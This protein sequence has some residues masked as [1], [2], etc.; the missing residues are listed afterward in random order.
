MTEC[1]DEGTLRA[2]LADP[3]SL[4]PED[5]KQIESHLTGCPTCRR[6]LENL[7]VLQTRVDAHMATL[8]PA[9]APDV[10][11]ALQK[12]RRTL[13]EQRTIPSITPA[14]GLPLPLEKQGSGARGRNF[15]QTLSFVRPSRR[16]ALV[17]GL[18]AAMLVLS[19]AAF[20][21]MRAAADEFLQSFRAK[22][23][24]FVPVDQSRIQQIMQATG[25]P[26]TL[27]LTAPEV[28]GNPR[29]IKVNSLDEATKLVNFAPGQPDAFPSAPT[30]TDYTVHEQAR[31]QTQVNI[32][33]TRELLK[34]LNISDVTLPDQLGT[35]PITADVPAT[36]QTTYSGA[37]YHFTLLQGTT[38]TVNL[39][40][41]VE[42]AQLGKAGLR[43]LGMQPDQ[44][45][46]LSREIDWSST[47]VVPFPTGLDSVVHVQVG[48]ADGLMVNAPNEYTG[49]YSG[50]NATV[51]YWQKGDR[52][53]VL[54]G[55]GMKVTPD[56]VLVVAKSVK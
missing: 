12:M 7:R 13:N 46:K 54:E 17:S 16:P 31:L 51:I 25:D 50:G 3:A 10:Q 27:F 42:L 45:D 52:F 33:N 29:N 43:L 38:P 4:T 26:T 14:P 32:A 6:S 9:G 53:F 1:C 2:Y 56:A 40:K 24:M 8:A 49:N 22:S 11:F 5:R 34:A 37:G 55:G 39:P 28:I 21:S 18:I 47:L 30:S 48:D 20:P 19:L 23:M 41:G 35:A 15:M 36:L 44:A